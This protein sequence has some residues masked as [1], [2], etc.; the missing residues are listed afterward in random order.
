MLRLTW[1]VVFDIV[2]S[3]S[4]SVSATF[5]ETGITTQKVIVGTQFMTPIIF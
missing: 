4:L 1:L 5:L 2:F 3:G